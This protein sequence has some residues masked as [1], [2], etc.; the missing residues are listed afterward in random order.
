MKWPKHVTLATR[1][2][3]FIYVCT[4][5][6]ERAGGLHGCERVYVLV[7]KRKPPA[8]KRKNLSCPED[9]SHKGMVCA[10][11]GVCSGCA[12]ENSNTADAYHR[13]DPK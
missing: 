11:C 7:P 9:S 13:K 12:V 4:H 2:R 6:D 1:G 5:S 10:A 3:G 8:K